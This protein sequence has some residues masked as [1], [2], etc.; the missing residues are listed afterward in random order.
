MG[1]MNTP[2]RMRWFR[3]VLQLLGAG[4]LLLAALEALEATALLRTF[5]SGA[6]AEAA[7]MAPAQ[8]LQPARLTWPPFPPRP[9]S[10]PSVHVVMSVCGDRGHEALIS[11]KSALLHSN[12]YTEYHFHLFTDGTRAVEADFLRHVKTFNLRGSM[13]NVHYHWVRAKPNSDV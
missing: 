3:G 4:V 6:P 11:L 7:S 10:H 9:V 12:T 13:Q 5:S 8:N 2:A 1:S